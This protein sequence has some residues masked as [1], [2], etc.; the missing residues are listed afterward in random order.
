MI[1][2]LAKFRITD[3]QILFH[4]ENVVMKIFECLRLE[5]I[6]MLHMIPY[7]CVYLT[8]STNL[9]DFLNPRPALSYDSLI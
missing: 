4:T 5:L 3:Q 7:I 2:K 6:Y 1:K 9:S 8:N